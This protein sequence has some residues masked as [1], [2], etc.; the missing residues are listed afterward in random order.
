MRAVEV[1]HDQPFM[2]RPMTVSGAKSKGHDEREEAEERPEREPRPV[3]L[4]STSPAVIAQ[5]E[6]VAEPG[7]ENLAPNPEHAT[8][9]EITTIADTD[10]EAR[11]GFEP[12][13]KSEQA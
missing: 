6:A 5:V 7:L 11:Y 4:A 12:K 10:L 1:L 2:G 9:V 13:E 8:G 3:V